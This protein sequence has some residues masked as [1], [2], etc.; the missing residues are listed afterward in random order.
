LNGG[1]QAVEG[2][3]KPAVAYGLVV[4]HRLADVVEVK[5]RRP[6]GGEQIRRCPFNSATGAVLPEGAVVGVMM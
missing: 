5:L 4:K 6:A 1:L 2:S 3:L